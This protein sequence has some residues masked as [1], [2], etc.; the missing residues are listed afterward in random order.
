MTI[1]D[2]RSPFSDSQYLEHNEYKEQINHD[3]L[4]RGHGD[5]LGKNFKIGGRLSGYQGAEVI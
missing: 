1:V 2:M 3:C 5:H 4:I